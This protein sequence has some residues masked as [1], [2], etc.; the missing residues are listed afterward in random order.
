MRRV[1]SLLLAALAGCAQASDEKVA[2][3]LWEVSG[4][5]GERAWLF[6]TIHALPAAVDW[7]SPP[8]NRALAGSD[9]LVM[10]IANPDDPAAIQRTYTGLAASKGLPPLMQRF[11]GERARRLAKALDKFGIDPGQFGETETW[12]VAL[13]L[14][15]AI[16]AGAESAHGLDS[17]IKR[18][19]GAK[20]LAELEGADT[21]LRMF[22]ALP[23]SEQRDLL[24]AVVDEALDGGDDQRLARAWAKGDMAALERETRSGLLADPELRAALFTRR[25]AEWT[26]RVDAMLR[27]GKHPLVAVGAAHM[28]GPEGLPA[29][30]ASKGYTV[31]R[32]Q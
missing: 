18:A 19:A 2:P 17:E 16:Q 26:M 13:T 6:G 1:V 20:P 22:D 29:A 15:Q 7:Q 11:A 30:L 27:E 28:A 14:S 31:T 21:Q 5:L 4:P 25:N 24:A 9:V 8:V 12:A 23:E 32:V 10:E 3:A